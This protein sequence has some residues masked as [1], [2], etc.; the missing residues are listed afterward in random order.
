MDGKPGVFRARHEPWLGRSSCKK[1]IKLPSPFSIQLHIVQPVSGNEN[2]HY[3]RTHGGIPMSHPA[4]SHK[5]LVIFLKGVFLFGGKSLD[6][7]N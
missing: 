4:V 7:V 6:L 2:V 1:G 3:R 5:L